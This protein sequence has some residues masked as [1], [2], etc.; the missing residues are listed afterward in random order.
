MVNVLK[1]QM[2]ILFEITLEKP[3]EIQ[4]TPDNAVVCS[5]TVRISSLNGAFSSSPGPW[6]E[7]NPSVMC[8][9]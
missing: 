3:A 2:D 7:E 6:R 4:I 1:I 9:I 8:I 5:S